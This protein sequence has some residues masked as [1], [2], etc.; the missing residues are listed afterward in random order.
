MTD[1]AKRGNHII[2]KAYEE[3]FPHNCPVLEITADGE[4][5][6]TCCYFLADG[7]TCPRHGIVKEEKEQEAEA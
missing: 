5:V 7:K 1:E 4:C 6:G 2:N 3:L